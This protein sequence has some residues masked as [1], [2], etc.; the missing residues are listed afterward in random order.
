[1]VALPWAPILCA[2]LTRV[3]THV[4]Q[5]SAISLYPNPASDLLIAQSASF[6]GTQ[7]TPMVY[8]VAGRRVAVDYSLSAGSICFNVGELAPGMYWLKFIINDK[9]ATAK[10]VKAGSTE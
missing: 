2:T 3:G 9:E 10:F 5:L 7:V 4:L 1:M 6:A 8:D